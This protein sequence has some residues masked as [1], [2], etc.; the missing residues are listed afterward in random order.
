M[1][2]IR[3]VV[4]SVVGLFS[5]LAKAEQPTTAPIQPYVIA[6]VI[7]HANANGRPDSANGAD[8][9]LLTL[10]PA[11]LQ[12]FIDAAKAQLPKWEK[13]IS[14]NQ[15]SI[16][17]MRAEVRKKGDINGGALDQQITDREA[18]IRN[19]QD[20]I[21][22]INEFVKVA[23]QT[24]DFVQLHMQ[25]EKWCPGQIDFPIA[26]D[27]VATTKTDELGNFI[28]EGL[29]PNAYTLFAQTHQNGFLR[30]WL[31]M[32]GIS[33]QHPLR[34]TVQNMDSRSIAYTERK[35]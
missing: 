18:M 28:F 14:D 22:S 12:P 35:E 19:A 5:L 34:V 16:D 27:V 29:K 23:P 1:T 31:E 13:L 6:G 21:R 15:K 3:F 2:R 33:K 7:T 10:H 20:Q 4:V 11:N 26:A 9:Y 30:Q 25:L 32:V 24:A 17:T 8:V